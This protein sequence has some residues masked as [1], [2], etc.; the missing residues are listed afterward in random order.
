VPGSSVLHYL[1]AFAGITQCT[2]SNSESGL[3]SSGNNCYQIDCGYHKTLK[4]T[5]TATESWWE[6]G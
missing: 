4:C 5:N 3:R 1:P 2:C 6:A